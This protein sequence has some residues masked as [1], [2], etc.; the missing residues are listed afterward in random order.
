MC[1]VTFPSHE[2]ILVHSCVQAKEEPNEIDTNEQLGIWDPS[3]E[4]LGFIS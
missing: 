2:E 1:Q 3:H 4:F